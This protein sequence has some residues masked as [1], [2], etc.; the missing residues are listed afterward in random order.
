[1]SAKNDRK[2]KSNEMNCRV[3]S[4][5]AH[6][7]KW[8]S[9]TKNMIDFSIMSKR[10]ELFKDFVHALFRIKVRIKRAIRG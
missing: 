4:T 10:L 1:M 5:E 3:G 8:I 7:I 6:G 2:Q 9:L